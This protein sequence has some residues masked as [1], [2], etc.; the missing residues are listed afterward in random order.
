MT[1]VRESVSRMDVESE[2]AEPWDSAPELS[3]LVPV[4]NEERT[5]GRTLRRLLAVPFP[6]PFEVIVVDDGSTDGSAEVIQRLTGTE[7][8]SV[9]RHEVNSGKGAAIQT[10]LRHARGRFM[11]IQDA[12]DELDPM[13]L[14]PM[15]EKVRT[16]V[17]PV[18]YGSRFLG[19]A[20]RFRFRPIYLANRLLNGLCNV[21]NGLRLT[22]M[23]TCYK[24]M[25]TDIARRLNLCSRGFAME[26]EITTKL[27]RMGIDILEHPIRYKPRLRAE[28]KKIRATDFFRYLLAMIRF[29]FERPS[30]I[31]I[32]TQLIAGR[33]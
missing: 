15:F 11:V 6:G 33:V 5:V 8:V 9:V 12:D 21:L 30:F 7:G 16:G 10:A 28:G 24:M 31:P 29:R 14:L 4:F 19:D 2:C 22:D 1:F 27:A 3:V 17:C 23:N 18:C 13:D 26:P 32:P 20:G 25:R